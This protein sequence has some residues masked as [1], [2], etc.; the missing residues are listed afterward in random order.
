MKPI[1]VVVAK[2]LMTQGND[3]HV[4]KFFHSVSWKKYIYLYFFVNFLIL[5]NKI[6]RLIFY[7]VTF[8]GGSEQEKKIRVAQYT[9]GM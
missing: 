8:K 7:Q 3:L 4:N 6:C 5:V 1:P 2:W 9:F